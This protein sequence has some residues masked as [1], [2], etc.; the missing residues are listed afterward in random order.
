MVVVTE[1][2]INIVIVPCFDVE[3]SVY[4]FQYWFIF[5]M[6]LLFVLIPLN[7]FVIYSVFK[8]IISMTHYDTQDSSIFKQNESITNK[9]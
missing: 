4:P 6:V 8:I 3:F 9:L 5:R 1:S 7:V 2:I